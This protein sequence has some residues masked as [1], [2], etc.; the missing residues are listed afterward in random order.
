MVLSV[1]SGSFDSEP[2]TCLYVSQAVLDGTV[3]LCQYCLQAVT[4]LMR[5]SLS[6][7]PSAVHIAMP[8]VISGHG[9]SVVLTCSTSHLWSTAPTMCMSI[10]LSSLCHGTSMELP[11]LSPPILILVL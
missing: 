8:W 4:A 3:L 2:Y 9:T 10:V 7:S 5:T 11:P 1:L 6:V